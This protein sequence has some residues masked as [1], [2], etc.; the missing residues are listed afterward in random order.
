METASKSQFRVPK[1][2]FSTNDPGNTG[3]QAILGTRDPGNTGEQAIWGTRDLGNAG[4]QSIWGPVILEILQHN[5][6]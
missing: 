2:D 3:E 4:E 6:F 5:P 1:P